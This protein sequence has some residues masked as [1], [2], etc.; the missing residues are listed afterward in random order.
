MGDHWFP[1]SPDVHT[2]AR[3]SFPAIATVTR[4]P[5]V[6]SATRMG[7]AIGWPGS[8]RHVEPSSVDRHTPVPPT[9]A[10]HVCGRD[11]SCTTSVAAPGTTLVQSVSTVPPSLVTYTPRR[12]GGQL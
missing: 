4:P 10:N 6:A 8:R 2:P 12:A 7:R 1:R 5:P 9:P 11:A 3:P